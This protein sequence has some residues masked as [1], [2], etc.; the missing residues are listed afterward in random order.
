VVTA[1]DAGGAFPAWAANGP[2]SDWITIDASQVGNGPVI[3]YTYYRTF[4]LTPRDVALASISGTWGIDDGGDLRLNGNLISSVPFDY[5]ATTPFSVGAGGGLFVPG[6]NTLTITMT[7]SDNAFE[8]VRLEGS[9][10]VPEPSTI[11]LSA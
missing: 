3:P 1:A 2:N 9:L 11:V 4:S 6:T 10:S 5:S 7:V 8:A